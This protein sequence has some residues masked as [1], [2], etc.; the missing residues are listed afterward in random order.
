MQ[1]IMTDN[2]HTQQNLTNRFFQ[3]GNDFLGTQYPIMCGA[4]TWISEPELVAAVSNSGAF[5][6]LAAGNTP[7]DE[8]KKQ[9]EATRKLTSGPFA[10]NLVTVAPA[11]REQL[12]MVCDLELPFIIFAGSFPNLEEI[13]MAKQSGAKVMCFASTLSIAR[14]M[15]RYG[16]D[17]IIL[18]GMEAGGHVGHVSLTVLL[19]QVLFELEDIPV[20]VAG[21]IA[22][23]K[24]GAHL[25]LMGASG[26]QMGTRFVLAEECKA[27]PEF[28]QK[29]R[30]ANARNAVATPQY[31]SRLPVVAVRALSNKGMEDF[32]KLQLDLIHK[33]DQDEVTRENAQEEVERF[34]MG[35]LRQAVQDG[36]I[37]HGSLMAGQSVGLVH[38]ES[39]VQEIINNFVRE[40]EEELQR[41]KSQFRP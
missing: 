31:D 19:Q 21:G 10:V 25:L 16:A 23:G 28:K 39:S 8:L 6:S 29:F 33:L 5:G 20:F 37:D 13:R 15:I 4:M 35:A 11:Y 2:N 30:K 34:W 14:R 3:T 36:D 38:E 17:A 27:H 24:M 18:E 1:K 40:A 22:S 12:E 32:R 7:A 9:I 41:V 26:V